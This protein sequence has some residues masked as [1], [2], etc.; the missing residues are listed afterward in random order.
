MKYWNLGNTTVRNPQR[1]KDALLVLKQQF[2]GQT[3]T[4]EVQKRYFDA[5]VEAGIIEGEPRKDGGKEQSGRKWGAAFNQLGLA[6]CWKT[7]PPIEVTAAGNALLSDDTLD[8]DVFLRQMLKIQLPSPTEGALDNAAI[9][10]FYLVLSV[11]VLLEQEG[12]KGISKEE[13]ALFVQPAY[14]DDQ[15]PA[16][17]E[18]IKEYRTE[19]AKVT[20][21]VVKRRFFREHLAAKVNELFA[22][23]VG[24]R[25]EMVKRLHRGYHQDGAFVSSSAGTDL[26][27]RLSTTGK[28]YNTKKAAAARTMFVDMVRNGSSVEELQAAAIS[29]VF[30]VRMDTLGDYAD[31]TVRYSA[32]TGVFAIGRQLLSL[33]ED[34]LNLAR[35]IVDAGSPSM[36]EGEEF[37]AT[38]HNPTLP[39]LPTDSTDFLERDIDALSDRLDELSVQTGSKRQEHAAVAGAGVL[40]LKRRRE[41]LEQELISQ[42]E[43]QFYRAQGRPDQVADIIS[44]FE[45][46]KEGEIIGGSDYLPAWA[47]WGVWR[48]FLSINTIANPISKTRGFKIDTELF[49]VHHAKG[50]AADLHFEYDEDTIV[51]AEITLNTGE[52]QYAAERE[53][54]RTHVAKLV[55]QNPK[56]NVIGV[57]VAP[58]IQPRTAYDFYT[59]GSAGDYSAQLGR[60]IRLNIVPLTIDQLCQLLPGQRLSCENSDDLKARLGELLALRPAPPNGDGTQWITR[61]NEYFGAT[62]AGAREGI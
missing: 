57:F 6:K 33:K 23:E 56:A 39:A 19:R 25:V 3:F 42:K 54:V 21:R 46:I 30:S 12:M 60:V 59:A 61:I 18:Q 62:P 2:E 7:K 40:Q 26:L 17:V 32:I 22:E 49:P 38:F 41:D 24:P 1:I 52:R 55:E 50:G 48:V 10:P 13:L 53:P 36:L 5:L 27:N 35:A 8:S 37:W 9:H 47:E 28:G 4:E 45:S 16:I 51:P 11:A 20:G 15:G 44:H 43:L 34:Q 14:R 31:T 58:T 29:Y